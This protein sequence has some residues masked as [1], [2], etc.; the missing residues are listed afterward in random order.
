[1]TETKESPALSAPLVNFTNNL[2]SLREFL[3]LIKSFLESEAKSYG[4]SKALDLIPLR[5]AVAEVD[6]KK[7]SRRREPDR[8]ERGK[9]RVGVAGSEG[10]GA[11]QRPNPG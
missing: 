3:S 10:A 1:M 7:S 6:Q 11:V 4:D 8:P 5:F 9:Q 2:E